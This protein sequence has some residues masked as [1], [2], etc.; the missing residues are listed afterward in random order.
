MHSPTLVVLTELQKLEKKIADSHLAEIEFNPE[1]DKRAA[2]RWREVNG[3]LLRTEDV[4][5]EKLRRDTVFSE[6]ELQEQFKRMCEPPKVN[7]ES[8]EEKESGIAEDDD[9]ST[10][11]SV[12]STAG[13][14]YAA[15]ITTSALALAALNSPQPP[16]GIA[17][18]VSGRLSLSRATSSPLN[19]T[20]MPR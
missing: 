11:S 6:E 19:L 13:T 12:S 2:A 1:K 16:S 5:M 8:S 10:G 20:F 7:P 3:G 9:D 4:D 14:S 18:S 17:P 15:P